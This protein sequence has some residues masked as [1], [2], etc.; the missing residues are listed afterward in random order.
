MSSIIAKESQ[1]SER[2][3]A[4]AVFNNAEPTPKQL[5]SLRTMVKALP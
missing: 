3:L 1:N 2:K 4:K 5:V